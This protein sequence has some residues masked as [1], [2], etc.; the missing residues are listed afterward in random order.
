MGSP[1]HE[2][3]AAPERAWTCTAQLYD[4][5]YVY[6]WWWSAFAAGLPEAPLL[7]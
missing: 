3:C 7:A 4:N 6:V 1:R 2:R 5:V